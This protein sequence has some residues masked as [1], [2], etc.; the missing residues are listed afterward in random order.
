MSI[1][2]GDTVSVQYIGTFSDG[3]EFDRS[4]PEQPLT[5]K[6]G[7]GQVIKGFDDAVTGKN[8]GDSFKVT[9]PA[10]QAY[11]DHDEDLVFEVEISQIPESITPEVGLNLHV[12]TDQGELEVTIIDITEEA[13]LLDANHPMAGEDLTFEITIDKVN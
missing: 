2:N 4:R 9:I 6:V 8:A 1:K 13:L 10:E 5:F 11:G 7:S 12:S 3:V